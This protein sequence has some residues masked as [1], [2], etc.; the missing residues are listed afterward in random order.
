MIEHSEHVILAEC[1]GGAQRRSLAT[2]DVEAV[3]LL[4]MRAAALL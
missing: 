1:Q 4:L 3:L 2:R